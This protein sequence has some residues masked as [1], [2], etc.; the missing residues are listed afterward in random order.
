M[1]VA[2][3]SC[4]LSTVHQGTVW[5]NVCQACR[6]IILSNFDTFRI[7]F[8]PFLL[9]VSSN[10]NVK[11][12]INIILQKKICLSLV[13]VHQ[14][15]FSRRLYVFLVD[16]NKLFFFTFVIKILMTSIELNIDVTLTNYSTESFK[17]SRKFFV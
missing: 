14:I 3:L 7:T 5:A 4:F 15:F 6:S 17:G 12:R 8:A 2:R 11:E 1:Q 10:A 9:C 13:S 16:T